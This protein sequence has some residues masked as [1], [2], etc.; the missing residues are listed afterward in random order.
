MARS[1]QPPALPQ[2]DFLRNFED[3]R[4]VHQA[5]PYY[6]WDELRH[7]D[8]PGDLDLE[9]WW[10]QLKAIRR[11]SYVEVPLVDTR[12]VPFRIGSPNDLLRRL[13]HLDRVMSGQSSYPGEVANPS[14][15]DRFLLASLQEEAVRSSQLEGAATTR[16]DAIDMLRSGREPRTADERMIA[17]NLVA[18]QWIRTKT[19]V[20]LTTEI[21]LE[22]QRILMDGV[23]DAGAA[24]RLRRG[25]ERVV[26]EDVATG[27][28]VH[29]PP[30]AAELPGRLERMCAFAN[31]A[32]AAGAFIHPISRA[33]A[34]HFWLAYDHPFVDGNGRTAR[35]LFYWSML[36]QG[37]WLTEF[38]SISRV[39]K[40][41]PAQYARA[42]TH[43]ES[44]DN[45]LTYFLFHQLAVLEKS[46]DGLVEY[47]QRKTAE[48][49][50]VERKLAVPGLN[51]RQLALLAHALRE[52]ETEYTV[53]GHQLRH[54]VVYDTARTDL[55][56][57][58]RR[59][60]LSK[61]KRGREFVFVPTKKLA[62]LAK[63]P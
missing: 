35:A 10:I 11:L 9:T 22:T 37:Y 6:H 42:F 52:P 43:T 15:R 5:T 60:Y 47:L 21:V 40:Q 59:R 31:D 44:D 2:L 39:I 4:R 54:G 16:R 28:V 12:G 41:A 55:L 48:I 51:A 7:R 58:A 57:L 18:M 20:P 36:R 62:A 23:I 29:T 61:H 49:R 27:D 63:P 34:L 32:D 38:L 53:A 56:E 1:S 45:D 46:L 33:I 50:S 14:T 30:P 25:D 13:H 8:P 24:G 17:N 19:D 26:V 3:L